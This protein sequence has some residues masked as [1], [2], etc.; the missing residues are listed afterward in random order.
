MQIDIM[1]EFGVLLE[2]FFLIICKRLSNVKLVYWKMILLVSYM[3]RV[4]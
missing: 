1:L 4:W 2:C 3:E